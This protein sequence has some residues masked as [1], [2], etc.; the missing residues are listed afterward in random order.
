[1]REARIILPEDDNAGASLNA[2]HKKL[3]SRLCDAFGG[4]SRTSGVGGWNNQHGTTFT[5]TVRIYDIACENS[6]QSC[7]ALL[8][9]ARW[10]RAEARQEAIYL[11]QP[12]GEVQFVVD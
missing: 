7:H 6:L 11:R 12:G 5:E 2:V 4:F 8:A 1:M 3:E 10:L 9:L